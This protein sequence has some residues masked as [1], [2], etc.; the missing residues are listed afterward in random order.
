MSRRI[1]IEIGQI[2]GRWT[3]K[4]TDLSRINSKN[5]LIHYLLVE[6]ECGVIKEVIAHSLRRG[7][8]KSCGCLQ[9]DWAKS[10]KS[11]VTH[12]RT[13]TSIY[14]IWRTMVKRCNDPSSTNYPNYGGR[15][16][17]VCDR[18]L[19][20]FEN[21]LADMGERPQNL[22]LDRINNDGNYELSNCRWTNN[23]IQSRNTRSNK[24]V[25]LYGKKMCITEASQ[26]LNISYATIQ[27]Y[28]KRNKCTYQESTD[29]FSSPD[30][31]NPKSIKYI[32][33]GQM[34]P[35]GEILKKLNIR[36]NKIHRTSVRLKLTIQQSID[37]YAAKLLISR[38]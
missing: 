3:V 1:V 26:M 20:S 23:I 13:R 29:Y 8:S 10:N 14:N 28:S 4:N 37:Y 34:L 32:L 15:G 5:E 16:I 22:S 31:K 11:G 19:N 18:W 7:A 21:F 30:Y 2:F 36:N 38:S 6:C 27:Q 9:K 17:K 25:M 24:H 12:G 35:M 33:L